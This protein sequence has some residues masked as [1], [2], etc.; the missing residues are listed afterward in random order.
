MISSTAASW[1]RLSSWATQKSGRLKVVMPMVTRPEAVRSVSKPQTASSKISSPSPASTSNQYQPP[2]MKG[3]RVRSN[4]RVVV[5]SE[6]T[7]AELARS[8]CP[9]AVER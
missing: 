3:A 9:L 6:S 5:V 8:T 2:S 1:A 7:G 4:W